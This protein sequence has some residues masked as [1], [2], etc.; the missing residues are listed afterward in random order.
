MINR[1]GLPSKVNA[2]VCRQGQQAVLS[3][4]KW[5]IEQALEEELTAYLG[6][7]RYEHLPQC[8]APEQTRSGFYPRTL[9]TQYALVT[10]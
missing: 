6:V 5:T 9:V 10:A 2:E 7:E 1:A 3:T 4:V 8:R